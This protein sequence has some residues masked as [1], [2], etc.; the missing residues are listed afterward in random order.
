MT[1]KARLFAVIIERNKII[2]AKTN[3][4]STQEYHDYQGAIRK[5]SLA[6]EFSLSFILLG[7]LIC[8]L[9]CEQNH[10]FQDEILLSINCYIVKLNDHIK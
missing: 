1:K 3:L 7:L 2:E 9:C 5:I 8:I 6:L 4:K 10:I